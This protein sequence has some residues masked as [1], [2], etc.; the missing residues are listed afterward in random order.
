MI[1]NLITYVL[2]GVA[3]NFMYDLLINKLG[4]ESTRFTVAE[5]ITA[6]ILWPILLIMFIIGI[7]KTLI[8]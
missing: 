1:S 5:R 2:V 7:I 8:K 6:T 3:L 4:D